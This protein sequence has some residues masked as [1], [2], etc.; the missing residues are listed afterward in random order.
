MAQ[1]SVSS[2][3]DRSSSMGYYNY[4]E[5]AK[6]D[7]A[8][9]VSIM[10]ANDQ[11]G[12]VAI[13]DT[14]PVLYTLNTLDTNHDVIQAALNVIKGI[15]SYGNTNIKNAL[16]NAHSMLGSASNPAKAIILLSDGEYNVGGDP[17]S[18]LPTDIPVYTI[19]LGNSSGIQTL[20]SIASQ[21]GGKYYFSPDAFEL[22]AIYNQIANDSRVAQ[23]SLN[24]RQQIPSYQFSSLPLQ[25]PANTAHISLGVNWLNSQIDYTAGTPGVNQVSVLL[26]DPNNQKVALPPT[27]EGGEFVTFH[28]HDP[29]PGQWTVGCWCGQVPNNQFQGTMG[30]F[31]PQDSSSL[32]LHATHLC[33]HKKAPVNLRAALDTKGRAVSE[34]QVRAYINSPLHSLAEI[35]QQHEQRL[36][37]IQTDPA[38]EEGMSSSGPQLWAL[39]KQLLPTENI[40]QRKTLPINVD[41]SVDNDGRASINIPP[42]AFDN[43]GEHNVHLE[44]TGKYASC[45]SRFSRTQQISLSA[46]D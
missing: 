19:A 20:Q 3:I 7:A 23:T 24:Q 14:S 43:V 17:L 13:D 12:L 30:G 31:E 39:H 34:L 46:T 42:F 9:F 37:T 29:L 44:I 10:R 26:R 5:P 35:K 22:A 15:S 21:T 18:G 1:V 16:T 45:G 32:S 27:F 2:I 11:I 41:A 40:F 25:V 36:N 33:Q 4:I 8:T 28:L 38:P 6:T